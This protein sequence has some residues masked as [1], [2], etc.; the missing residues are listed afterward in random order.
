MKHARERSFRTAKEAA[1]SLGIPYGTYSGH[2]AGSRGIKDDELELYAR[3]FKVPLAWLSFGIGILD[4]ELC[5]VLKIVGRVGAGAQIDVSVEQAPAQV[6]SVEVKLQ[7][8]PG[9]IAFEILG[10]SMYPKYE[11]GD[12]V[13]AEE[14][15]VPIDSL[16]DGTEAA[17]LTLDGL[18]YLKKIFR[19]DQAGVFNLESHNAAPIRG[20][21]IEWA[22]DIMAIIPKRKW[23]SLSEE[24]RAKLVKKTTVKQR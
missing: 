18:R 2:E 6:E 3:R 14:D 23:R 19:T 21:Q 12:L 5:S 7:L 4:K 22:A 15:G 9:V 17:V 20:V 8:P 16:P 13:V 10:D 11:D 1:L 24:D